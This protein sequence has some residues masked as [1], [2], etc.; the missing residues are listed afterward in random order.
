[1]RKIL[2]S[3]IAAGVLLTGAGGVA[4]AESGH[5]S[6]KTEIASCRSAMEQDMTQAIQRDKVASMPSSC[7]NL[8][9]KQLQDIVGQIM[10]KML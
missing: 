10:T 7:A 4:L 8:S 6:V 3:T 2:V 5:P 9:P 1:M